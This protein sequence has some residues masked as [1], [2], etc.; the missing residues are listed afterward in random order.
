MEGDGKKKVQKVRKV[1]G[2]SC[3]ES[4]KVKLFEKIISFFKNVIIIRVVDKKM[5]KLTEGYF[6]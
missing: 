3:I 4:K 6:C 1:A 5:A 2:L